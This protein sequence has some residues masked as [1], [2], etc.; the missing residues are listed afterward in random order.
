MWHRSLQLNFAHTAEISKKSSLPIGDRYQLR[1][2]V[3]Q[4]KTSSLLQ[5]NWLAQTV[6]VEFSKVEID[7]RLDLWISANP[8]RNRLHI[9]KFKGHK[10]IIYLISLVRRMG[11]G[12]P[13][14]FSIRKAARTP[15]PTDTAPPSIPSEPTSNS[16]TAESVDRARV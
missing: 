6:E 2:N 11:V 4:A 15:T 7:W 5:Y 9:L 8:M 13:M 10:S 14:T 1:Q 16:C 12:H 3:A